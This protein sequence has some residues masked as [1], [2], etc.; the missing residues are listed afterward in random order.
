[1]ISLR[2]G[3]RAEFFFVPREANCIKP[4]MAAD[5][6]TRSC[7]A[8]LF[9]FALI[10]LPAAAG[11]TTLEDSA[12]ELGQKIA[13]ILPP[14]E[15]VSCEIRNI[16]SLRPGEVARIDQALKSE[17]QER[18]VRLVASGGAATNVVVALSENFRGLVW[19][20]EIRRGDNPHV[21]LIAVARS[22]E[23]RAVSSVM[24]VT[25]HSEKF[26]EGQEHILDAGEIS[27]GAGKSWLVLLLPTGLLIQDQQTGSTD[28]MEITSDQSASRSPMGKIDFGKIGNTIGFSLPPRI[29]ALDLETRRL[30][31]CLPTDGPVDAP[32]PSRFPLMIDGTPAGPPPPGKGMELVIPSICAAASEFLASGSGD[33]TQNDSL[34]LFQMKPGGPVAVSSELEFPGP[35]LGLHSAVGPQRAVVRNLTTGNYEAYRL[36]FS[37]GQ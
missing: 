25:I 15:N 35:I 27:D 33:Y 16:S 24:P 4:M 26:W 37:C 10:G 20:G 12:K 18:G 30:T 29:C 21:V 5:R 14:Q 2:H 36:S 17:L 32:V 23:N 22:S 28:T 31:M 1:M 9:L 3:R 8:I 6:S 19:T 7:R 11:S 13:A 34:Q